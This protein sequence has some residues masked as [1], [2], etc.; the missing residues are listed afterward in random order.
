MVQPICNAFEALGE[1]P[2]YSSETG[3]RRFA[4][5]CVVGLGGFEPPTR[6]L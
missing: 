3:K 5:D 4:S 1:R 6:P 2:G